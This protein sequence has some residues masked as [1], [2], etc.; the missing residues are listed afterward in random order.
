M[1]PVPVPLLPLQ[2]RQFVEDVIQVLH[3][4]AQSFVIKSKLLL[5]QFVEVPS[6]KVPEAH[7][8]VGAPVAPVPVPL[9]PLHD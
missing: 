8:Q 1:A 9:F 4:F 3:K 5:M 2:V 7:E 6:S